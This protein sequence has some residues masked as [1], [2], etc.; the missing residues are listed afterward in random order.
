M[1]NE[2][3]QDLYEG[4][5][6]DLCNQKIERLVEEFKYIVPATLPN[7]DATDL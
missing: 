1:E 2:W 3:W 4:N 7:D 5:L 6:A